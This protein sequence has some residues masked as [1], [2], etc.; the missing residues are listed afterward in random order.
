MT[1]YSKNPFRRTKKTKNFEAP[2]RALECNMTRSCPFFKNLHNPFGKK[3]VF[4]YPVSE[5]LD[6]KKLK[7]Q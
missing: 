5:L 7:K 3:F 1:E 4:R 2:G 6:Y